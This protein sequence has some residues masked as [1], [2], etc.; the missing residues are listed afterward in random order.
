MFYFVRFA[1]NNITQIILLVTLTTL[2]FYTLGSVAQKFFHF[3]TR[4]NN[5]AIPFGIISY[6][7]ITFILYTPFIYFRLEEAWAN[8]FFY[9]YLIKQFIFTFVVLL[10]INSLLTKLNIPSWKQVSNFFISIIIIGLLLWLFHFLLTSLGD[11]SI[12]NFPFFNSDKEKVHYQSMITEF[13]III[14]M[15]NNIELATLFNWV[16]PFIVISLLYWSS[17]LL[18]ENIVS[19]ISIM[20]ATL[21]TLVIIVIF[22]FLIVESLI[23]III[24]IIYLYFVLIFLYAKET[25]G[26]NLIIVFAF[27]VLASLFTISSAGIV[28]LL[29]F[30]IPTIGYLFMRAKSTAS[31][32][33]LFIS[34]FA[35]Q[36]FF[37]LTVKN[38]LFGLI[39]L[40]IGII[41]LI[42]MYAILNPTKVKD[43]I[44]VEKTIKK[45]AFL[46]LYLSLGI[47]ILFSL[48]LGVKSDN[49]VFKIIENGFAK[50]EYETLAISLMTLCALYLIFSFYICFFRK[51]KANNLLLIT[52]L[53]IVIGFNPLT[54]PLFK[55]INSNLV[56]ID[57]FQIYYFVFAICIFLNSFKYLQD[58]LNFYHFFNYKNIPLLQKMFLNKNINN[59]QYLFKLKN[60]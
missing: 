49:S 12:I 9:L 51:E 22:S 24:P 47:T 39:F 52:S 57:I 33:L 44:Q 11:S 18:F 59:N 50:V 35:I 13:N 43:L 36:L 16:I 15:N 14:D 21:F 6:F 37:I 48:L 1:D 28:L 7:L 26:N 38:I 10:F 20:L 19:L 29:L 3:K 58:K 31:L 8:L 34:F 5:F 17:K 56:N 42:P 46:V 27:F 23:Y 4:N 45:N 25:F 40:I 30:G 60:K 54:L 55:Y 41:I 32:F 2:L 53:I